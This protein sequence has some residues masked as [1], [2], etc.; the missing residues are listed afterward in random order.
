MCT[1]QRSGSLIPRRNSSF[2]EAR[3]LIVTERL[4]FLPKMELD[5]VPPWFNVLR[6]VFNEQVAI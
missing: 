3:G 4:H 2:L 6:D 5:A 1:G